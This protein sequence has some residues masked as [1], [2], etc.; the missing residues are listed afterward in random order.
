M[1]LADPHQ[2]NDFHVDPAFI[3]YQ[4]HNDAQQ[5]AWFSL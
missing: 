2:A 5:N 3:P 1:D 4:P